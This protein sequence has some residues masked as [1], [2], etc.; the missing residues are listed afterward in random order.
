M[1]TGEKGGRE[2]RE[3]RVC[4]AARSLSSSPSCALTPALSAA[5]LGPQVLPIGGALVVAA[6]AGQRAPFYVHAL[7]LRITLQ[8][9]LLL[10]EFALVRGRHAHEAFVCRR[11]PGPIHYVQAGAAPRVRSPPISLPAHR[12]ASQAGP[13][14]AK[15]RP[16]WID[17]GSRARPSA[18]LHASR[19]RSTPPVSGG[20]ASWVHAEHVESSR[21]KKP[22]LHWKAHGP[23]DPLSSGELCSTVGQSSHSSWLF[24]VKTGRFPVPSHC[25]AST[26][27]ARDESTPVCPGLR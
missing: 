3:R 20:H 9:A 7:G 19:N 5:Y 10:A 6:E 13:G 18:Y 14:R 21:R 25:S 17:K 11:G 27:S 26:H 15:T 24:W 2:R 4:I 16:G 22:A 12:M 8:D 23:A 1:I